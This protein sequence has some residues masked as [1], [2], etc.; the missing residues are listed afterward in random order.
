MI[1][2]IVLAGGLAT[3][4][5]GGDKGFVQIGGKTLIDR[6][7][8][9]LEPQCEPLII[10]ANGDPGRFSRLGLPVVADSVPGN[11]GPLAGVLAGLDWVADHAPAAAFVATAPSDTPFLPRDFVRRLQERASADRA[12]IACARSGGRVH[13]TAS[14]W[15]VALRHDLR[16]ALIHDG[17]RRVRDFVQPRSVTYVEWPAEPFDPFLNVNTPDDL[18]AAAAIAHRHSL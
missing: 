2:G 6:V 16:E 15:T 5:G 11:V 10:S 13:F 7:L 14:L 12:P 18:A 17:L 3:R 8:A 9:R 4:L 1:A